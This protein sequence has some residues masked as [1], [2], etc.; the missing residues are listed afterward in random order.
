VKF[1][2]NHYVGRGSALT[3]GQ[4]PVDDPSLVPTREDFKTSASGGELSLLPPPDPTKSA[5]NG[6]AARNL[7][8]FELRDERPDIAG[9]EFLNRRLTFSRIFRVLI[10]LRRDELSLVTDYRRNSRFWY[11]VV[12]Q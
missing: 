12:K 5:S 6:S 2:C 1:F 11:V 9:L 4:A 8:I 7:Y 10:N 3:G